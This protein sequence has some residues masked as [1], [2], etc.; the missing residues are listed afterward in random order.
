MMDIIIAFR[1][2]Q[3]APNNH[4]NVRPREQYEMHATAGERFHIQCVSRL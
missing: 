2:F 1:N 3:N 4:F